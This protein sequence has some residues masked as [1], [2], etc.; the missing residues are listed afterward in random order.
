MPVVAGVGAAMT[1]KPAR[2]TFPSYDVGMADILW[3][4]E[5]VGFCLAEFWNW[6]AYLYPA[7][8]ESRAPRPQDCEEVTARTLADLRRDLRERVALK[9]RWWV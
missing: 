3:E 7:V 5:S 1:D 2:L 4:G 8:Q 6:R 9:G